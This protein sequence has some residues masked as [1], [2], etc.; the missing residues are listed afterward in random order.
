MLLKIKNVYIIF[1]TN[2]YYVITNKYVITINI[3]S[4]S[5]RHLCVVYV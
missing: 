3:A 2:K 1:F 5:D 4:Q